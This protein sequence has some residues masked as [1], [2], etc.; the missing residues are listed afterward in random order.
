MKIY[1]MGYAVSS[2]LTHHTAPLDSES[3]WAFKSAVHMN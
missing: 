2:Q 1:L 3:E